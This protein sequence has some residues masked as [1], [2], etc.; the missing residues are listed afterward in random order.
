MM[1]LLHSNAFFVVSIV[2]IGL[3]AF[4][5][6]RP[7]VSVALTDCPYRVSARGIVHGPES[8]FWGL[9]SPDPC[10]HSRGDARAYARG[11]E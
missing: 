9:T 5:L 8:P 1:R 11:S 7:Y 10:F 6:A 3:W 2:V 4:V